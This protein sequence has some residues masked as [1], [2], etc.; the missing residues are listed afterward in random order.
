[1]ALLVDGGRCAR[2]VSEH[3]EEGDGL[4]RAFQW[5]SVE[6]FRSEENGAFS[7]LG[8]LCHVEHTW[9]ISATAHHCSVATPGLDWSAFSATIHLGPSFILMLKHDIYIY[10]YYQY[11]RLLLAHGDADPQRY[12]LFKVL[13][14]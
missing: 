6:V 5:R 7:C 1:M 8:R 10:I 12:S 14:D 2:C 3:S 9:R 11:S 4:R 13:H